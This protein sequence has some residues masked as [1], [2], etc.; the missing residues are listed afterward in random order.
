MDIGLIFPGQG[1]QYPG[2]IQDF[3]QEFTQVQALFDLVSEETGKD[4]RHI[5]FDASEAEL[6]QTDNTQLAVTLANLS[7]YEAVKTLG[8]TI[9]A[10]A[11]FSLGEYSALVVSGVLSL[12]DA[13]RLVNERGKIMEQVSVQL[14]ASNASGDTV[15]MTAVLGLAPE[16]IAE[17]LAGQEGVYLAMYNSP[18]QGVVAGYQRARERV[19]ELLKEAGAKRIIPLK[20][21]GPFHTPLMQDART[22]FADIAH[23]IAFN[24]PTIAYYNNV[25]GTQLITG[26]SIRE[27]CIQQIISPVQWI[28]EEQE[29]S[30]LGLSKL[31]EAGPGTVLAGLWRALAKEKTEELTGLTPPTVDSIASLEQLDAFRKTII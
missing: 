3:Y 12:V 29:L 25:D 30:A 11:G 22:A 19:T 23:T 10:V 14:S 1:A 24:T 31:I 6:Q 15:G 2:M 7:V 27:A 16:R 13:I 18:V 4:M 20:V 21:S 5:L 9:R 8:H 26:E 28:R 17:L